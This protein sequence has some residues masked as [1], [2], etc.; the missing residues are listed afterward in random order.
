MSIGEAIFW[1]IV[2]V[3]ALTGA[4]Y[5]SWLKRTTPCPRVGCRGRLVPEAIC[6]DIG[7]CSMCDNYRNMDGSPLE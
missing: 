2:T 3:A 4:A 1:L 6:P 5:I 7:V